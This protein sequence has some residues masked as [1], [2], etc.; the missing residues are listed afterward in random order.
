VVEPAHPDSNYRLDA[1]LAFFLNL[2]QNLTTLFFER[3]KQ[4]PPK[5]EISG[6][7]AMPQ[8]DKILFIFNFTALQFKKELEG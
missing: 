3:L 6:T 8:P 5:P 2:F 4:S 7:W 1:V